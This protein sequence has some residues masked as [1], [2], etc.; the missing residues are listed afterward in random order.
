M[1][2]PESLI[3]FLIRFTEQASNLEYSSNISLFVYIN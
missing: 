2:I 3:A 1:G